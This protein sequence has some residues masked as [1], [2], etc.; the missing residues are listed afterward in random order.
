MEGTIFVAADAQDVSGDRYVL[1]A[2]DG[3][4]TTKLSGVLLTED[5]DINTELMLGVDNVEV[6]KAGD[7]IKI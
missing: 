7:V 5:I 3:D 6:F 1:T 4:W 2:Y